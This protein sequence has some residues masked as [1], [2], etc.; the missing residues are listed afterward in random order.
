MSLSKAFLFCRLERFPSTGVINSPNHPDEYPSSN[1]TRNTWIQVERGL[2]LSLQFT[3][4]D[5]SY[6]SFS[7]TTHSNEMCTDHLAIMDG[8]GTALMR[9]SC[10]SLKQGIIL[11]ASSTMGKWNQ[12]NGSTLPI[13][14]T[15]RSNIVSLVFSAMSGSMDWTGW[16]VSWSAVTP[17]ECQ[18]V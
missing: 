9:K 5:I 17:G 8:D 6:S 3:A 4:W 13:V 15:S 18:H 11:E 7:L 14:K 12:Q 2:V 1:N 16:S 10:G